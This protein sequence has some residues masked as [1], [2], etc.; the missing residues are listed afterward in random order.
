[1]TSAAATQPRALSDREIIGQAAARVGVAA[2]A[3][4]ARLREDTVRAV[5]AGEPMP[6][7]DISRLRRVAEDLDRPPRTA[8]TRP[9]RKAPPPGFEALER[10]LAALDAGES[11]RF[12]ASRLQQVDHPAARQAVQLLR[13]RARAEAMQTLELAL[14]DLAGP[15]DGSAMTWVRPPTEPARRDDS[16]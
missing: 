8:A 3:A 10:A 1:M 12:V 14:L 5:L 11:S 9:E 7:R 16:R 15:A 2:L 13:G 6:P 4:R